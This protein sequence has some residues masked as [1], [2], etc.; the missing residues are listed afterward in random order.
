MIQIGQVVSEIFATTDRQ[1]CPPPLFLNS[2][3]QNVQIRQNEEIDFFCENNTSSS[4]YVT[5]VRESKN[6][7]K[8]S[9]LDFLNFLENGA[10]KV[11]HFLHVK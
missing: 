2:D 7:E 8:L 10:I 6:A 9:F 11:F 5:V 4:Y 1:T 3:L